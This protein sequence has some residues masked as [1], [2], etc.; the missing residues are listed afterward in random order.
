MS[1]YITPVMYADP[2]GDLFMPLIILI[3]AMVTVL[4]MAT[5]PT[6]NNAGENASVSYSATPD[7]LTM[8]I[9]ILG[10]GF[11][12]TIEQPGTTCDYVNGCQDFTQ[13]GGQIAVFGINNVSYEDGN[14]TTALSIWVFYISVDNY[15]FFNF[16][17]YGAGLSFGVSSG[18][19]GYGSGTASF[20]IDFLGLI[21]DI[22][23]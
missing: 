15:D 14:I 2:N 4:L 11:S 19:P 23:S 9:D 3:S 5:A 13:T 18:S 8:G 6:E 12:Y 16:S 20:D 1:D 21:R 10:V 7:P 22:F 17:S